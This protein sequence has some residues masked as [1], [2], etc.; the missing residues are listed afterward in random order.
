MTETI[1]SRC[2]RGVP[3]CTGT[4]CSWT[5]RDCGCWNCHETFCYKCGAT[6]PIADLRGSASP[7]F[8]SLPQEG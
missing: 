6:D 8:P 5:C 3:G 7:P 1:E 2:S 4:A